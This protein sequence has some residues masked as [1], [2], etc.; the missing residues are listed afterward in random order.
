M[1]K[2]FYPYAEISTNNVRKLIAKN[3][4]SIRKLAKTIDVPASTLTDGLNSIKGIS[5]DSLV[6][7]SE[8][9]NITVDDLC[10]K[11]LF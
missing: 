7:I 6:R 4:T 9:F 3:G 11:K 2:Q 1:N 10:N 8:H 5:I